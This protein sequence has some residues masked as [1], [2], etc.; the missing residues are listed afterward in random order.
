MTRSWYHDKFGVGN[1]AF[2]PL[3]DYAGDRSSDP[4]AV[5]GAYLVALASW[6]RWLDFHEGIDLGPWNER[7][8]FPIFRGKNAGNTLSDKS[9]RDDLKLML[10]AQGHEP[11][12]PSLRRG[13]AEF[14]AEVD[15]QMAF[16][17]GGLSDLALRS[18]FLIPHSHG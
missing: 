14:Y 15:R 17:Q 5:L 10:K 13:G 1:Q 6:G 16:Q 3:I 4:L 2:L 12:G 8:L 18:S 7:V 9:A 11:E